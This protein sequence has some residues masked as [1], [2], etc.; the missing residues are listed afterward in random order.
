MKLKEGLLTLRN[1]LN[2]E[3]YETVTKNW[4][5]ST[6]HPAFL[7]ILHANFIGDMYE[8]PEVASLELE[9]T[10]PWANVHFSERVWYTLEPTSITYY[11]VK[12]Y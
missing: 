7:E 4:Q 2:D 12:G 1:K 11:V 6:D 5:G 3:G 10:Q 9:A 8:D